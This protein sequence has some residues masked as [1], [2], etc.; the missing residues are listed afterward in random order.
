MF[1]SGLGIFGGGVAGLEGTLQKAA[2]G[3]LH[4]ASRLVEG[5]AKRADLGNR[6]DYN[7]VTAF[8]ADQLMAIAN[9]GDSVFAPAVGS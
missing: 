9:A 5:F 6:R 4:H 2:K 8:K 7:V 1:G 3:V